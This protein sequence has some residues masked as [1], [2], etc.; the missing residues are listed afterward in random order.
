MYLSG[1]RPGDISRLETFQTRGTREKWMSFHTFFDKFILKKKKRTL[2]II[3]CFP[4][5]LTSVLVECGRKSLTSY[6]KEVGIYHGSKVTPWDAWII[7]LE[8][9][10][11]KYS[12]ALDSVSCQGEPWEAVVAV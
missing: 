5:L 1:K 6:R 4:N 2:A 3:V 11:F 12:S 10:G 7:L 8:L 9:L